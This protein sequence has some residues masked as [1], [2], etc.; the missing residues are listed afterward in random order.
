M[1]RLR[2]ARRAGV[3]GVGMMGASVGMGL[4]RAGWHVV[5]ADLDPAA[6]VVAL[7]AGAVD[8]LASSV[9][10]MGRLDLGVV[11]VPPSSTVAAA[12]ALVDI[13][14][15]VVTDVASVKAP[16]AAALADLPNFVGGHPMAGSERSGPTAAC[17][18]LFVDRPWALT[19]T[20]ATDPGAVA[21][22]AGV[23]RTL[24][25]RPV[26]VEAA[27]HDCA[28]ALVSHVPHVVA[29]ALGSAVAGGPDVD[30]L[31]RLVGPGFA[32]ATR[33]GAGCPDLW[34]DILLENAD[35]VVAAL[36]T[37]A[38]ALGQ[39][40]R[41]VAAG[42]RRGTVSLLRAGVRGRDDLLTRPGQTSRSRAMLTDSSTLARRPRATR[43]A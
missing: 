15:A 21:A 20:A 2:T 26:V 32:S 38:T 18:D 43:S 23:V 16:I 25:A 28:V 19:P 10:A 8:E 40:R 24:G 17:V 34:A 31:R 41:S 5:G 30:L 42:D 1:S 33:I 12:R 37:M 13:G 29:A 9:A 4:R 7:E 11:A 6:A 39:V 36:D 3:V 27:R 14:A 22:V 35:A